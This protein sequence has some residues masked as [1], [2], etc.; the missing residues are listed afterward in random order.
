MFA[1]TSYQ[2]AIASMKWWPFGYHPLQEVELESTNKEQRKIKTL[3]S[4]K[5]RKRKV[6]GASL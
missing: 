6:R 2:T 4:R 5:E 1:Q 3:V